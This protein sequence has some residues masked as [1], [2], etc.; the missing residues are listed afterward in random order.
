MLFD[1]WQCCV[2]LWGCRSPPCTEPTSGGGG[3]CRR[4]GH[5]V[6]LSYTA[7][8]TLQESVCGVTHGASLAAIT[9]THIK[10]K[11]ATCCSYGVGSVDRGIQ[12]DSEQ[13]NSKL[14]VRNINFCFFIRASNW[15]LLLLL[16]VPVLPCIFLPLSH[17]PL[18]PH[19]VIV[20]IGGGSSN[21]IM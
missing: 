6:C 10:K 15:V 11:T 14:Y 3:G 21:S 19:L 5:S 17:P 16:L 13:F 4:G 8:D 18:Y 20:V 9:L 1:I 2:S 7:S 12:F